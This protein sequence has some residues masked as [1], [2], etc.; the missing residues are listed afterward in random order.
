M[1]GALVAEL[2]RRVDITHIK[3]YIKLPLEKMQVQPIQM[4]TLA[5][6][7]IAVSET[8]IISDLT[9]PR[10]YGLDSTIIDF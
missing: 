3:A 9:E 7:C 1:S 8:E 6:E 10:T 4:C 2:M 5:P